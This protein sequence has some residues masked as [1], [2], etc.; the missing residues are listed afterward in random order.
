MLR[1]RCNLRVVLVWY[2]DKYVDLYHLHRVAYALIFHVYIL[3]PF[4]YKN[5]QSL[6]FPSMEVINSFSTSQ[7]K[8]KK[9]LWQAMCVCAQ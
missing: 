8:K 1:E 5:N 4:F 6:H 2:C 9:Q 3:G 7:K